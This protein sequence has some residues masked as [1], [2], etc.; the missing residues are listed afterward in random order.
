[1]LLLLMVLMCKLLHRLMGAVLAVVIAVVII[2]VT[3]TVKITYGQIVQRAEV[4]L[5]VTV[6]VVLTHRHIATKV[7]VTED[8]RVVQ[9]NIVLLAEVVPGMV[10][11]LVPV[12][13]RVISKI[14]LGNFYVS[15]KSLRGFL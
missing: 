5:Q 9:E 3:V 7:S 14:D 10:K 11:Q 6:Q 13:V 4:G 1:M 8:T 15:C 2:V 12:S